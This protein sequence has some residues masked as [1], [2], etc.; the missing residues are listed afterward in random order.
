[1]GDRLKDK[2]AIVVGAGQSPGETIGNGRATAILFARE[3]AK[4]MLVDNRLESAHETQAMIEQ[5]GGQAISF[6]ADVTHEEECKSM[7]A[8]CLKTWSCID[9]LHNNVGIGERGK[10]FI[11]IPVADWERFMDVNLK[12]MYLTC[13]AVLPHMLE[14]GSG[15]IINISSIASLMS[16]GAVA[17][18]SSKAA[19]NA[20]THG[21]A[22]EAAPFGIRV[23]AILPG[24][25]ETPMAI[26][27]RVRA[28]NEPREEIVNQRNQRVP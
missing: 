7:V 14:R 15:V 3:G 16:T 21:L 27:G 17:Y 20:L 2:V 23:N 6:Q 24:L 26:E 13:K 4:V 8:A 9:V 22:L 18:K 5:E 1:M 25:M 11:Y 12:S 28:Y 10:G 19:V